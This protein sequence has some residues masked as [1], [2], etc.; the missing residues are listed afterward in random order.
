MFNFDSRIQIVNQKV[1]RPNVLHG[2]K[3]VF[4]RISKPNSKPNLHHQAG[5]SYKS[6]PLTAPVQYATNYLRF[7]F[8]SVCEH[9]RT[10]L[11]LR[12]YRFT[13]DDFRTLFHHTGHPIIDGLGE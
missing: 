2:E 13:R 10:R 1:P 4:S 7:V 9:L 3:F 12:Q 11:V 5:N 6:T 8:G